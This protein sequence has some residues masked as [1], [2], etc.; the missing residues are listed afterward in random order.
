MK[1][2]A[3]DL[4]P[5]DAGTF[6]LDPT[7]GTEN[8]PVGYVDIVGHEI[9]TWRETPHA[10]DHFVRDILPPLPV[11]M[12]FHGTKAADIKRR[13]PALFLAMLMAAAGMCLVDK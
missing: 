10:S 8:E 13:K 5:N 6:A 4:G 12:F 7:K 11:V 1:V 9:L 3:L 2:E